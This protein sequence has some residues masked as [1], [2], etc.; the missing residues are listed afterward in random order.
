[1][2][3]A[4]MLLRRNALRRP[5]GG[6][7]NARCRGHETS[8]HDWRL[9]DRYQDVYRLAS[10]IMASRMAHPVL[11]EERCWALMQI[12]SLGWRGVAPDW[13]DARARQLACPTG[14]ND[15]RGLVLSFNAGVAAAEF[16]LP[17]APSQSS[18]QR[19]ADISLESPL[20]L[21]AAGAEPPCQHPRICRL[22]ARSSAVLLAR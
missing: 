4:G 3:G 14:E 19:A 1:M 17:P 5:Q 9:L 22:G 11:S 15:R 7:N 2:R 21:F 13:S 12:R 10:G 20:N 8:W 16:P 6:I 18:W